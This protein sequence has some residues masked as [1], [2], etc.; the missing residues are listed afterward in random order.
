MHKA[1]VLC[2]FVKAPVP[3]QVKTRLAMELGANQATELYRRLGR[4]VV[5]GVVGEE[6]ETVVWY[7]PPSDAPLVR[8]WLDGLGV[9]R[10]LLQSG[11]DLGDRLCT[12]FA[13]HFREGARR[14]VIIGS[15]CPGIDAGLVAQALAALGRHDLVLG[16]A[17]DGGYYLIGMKRP[18]EFLFEGIAWSTSSVAEETATR[19]RAAGLSCHLLL[20]LRDVDTGADARAAGLP[21]SCWRPLGR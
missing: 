16:P 17:W 5:Q 4:Q 10:F 18:H 14:V 19:A 12:A 9:T 13:K 20:T 2:V 6:Y 8:A 21:A 15:D 11:A 7:A 3:G 1:H